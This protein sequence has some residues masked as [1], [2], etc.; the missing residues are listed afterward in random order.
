MISSATEERE[1]E[2]GLD[3]ISIHDSVDSK[4][5]MLALS[6]VVE[7]EGWV[8]IRRREE[9]DVSASDVPSECCCLEGNKAESVGA[10][11]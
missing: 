6:I 2:D 5:I 3:P 4:T 7:F 10:A 1:E 8:S 11:V 9:R